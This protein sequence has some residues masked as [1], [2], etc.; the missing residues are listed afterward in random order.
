MRK[1]SPGSWWSKKH[2]D[3]KY[4]DKQ[5]GYEYS[6]SLEQAK[7]IM[8]LSCFYCTKTPARGIDRLDNEKGHCSGNIAPCCEKCNILLSDLPYLAKIELRD[9][10]RRIFEK[11]L[12][13]DWQPAY[14]TYHPRNKTNEDTIR[15]SEG[16]TQVTGYTRSE[17]NAFANEVLLRCGFG[18]R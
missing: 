10:L 6:F 8:E 13:K 17:E 2:R 4:T 9:G 5:K 18:L 14:K 16:T 1:R 7:A 12:L 3:Y 11:E 15:P